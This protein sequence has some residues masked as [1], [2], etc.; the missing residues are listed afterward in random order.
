MID[1]QSSASGHDYASDYSAIGAAT[2]GYEM[3]LSKYAICIQ[4]DESYIY[5]TGI[6]LKRLFKKINIIQLYLPKSHIFVQ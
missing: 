5:I 4:L 1:E 6:I 3:K 2:D